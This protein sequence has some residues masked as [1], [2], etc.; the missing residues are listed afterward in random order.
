MAL[1]AVTFDSNDVI[2]N[3]AAMTL[4][5]QFLEELDFFLGGRPGGYSGYINGSSHSGL[6]EDGEIAL[7]V[8]F[9]QSKFMKTR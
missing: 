7:R 4:E 1:G 9:V 6:C 5:R 2:V 8:I 3:Q